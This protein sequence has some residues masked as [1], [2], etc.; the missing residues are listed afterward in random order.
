MATY[1]ELA[2]TYATNAKNEYLNSLSYLTDDLAAQ[3]KLDQ[4]ALTQKYNNLFDQINRQQD[5]VN[6]QYTQDA[7]SAY[8]NKLLAG[9]ALDESLSQ[10]GLSTGGF[11]VNQR[12][13]N[14]T[15]YGQNLAALQQTRSE[16]LRDIANQLTDAM[17]EYN[18][19]NTQLGSDYLARV[20]A[21]K[22][23]Q[24]AMADEQ[25]QLAYNQFL[26]DLKY[27]DQLKQYQE[28]F[29]YQ[30][31]QDEIANAQK[32]AQI[33]ASKSS[34]SGSNKLG[35]YATT[36][37]NQ[38]ANMYKDY[39][40]DGTQLQA[41]EKTLNDDLAAGMIS[42]EEYNYMT[43]LFGIRTAQNN[44]TTSKPISAEEHTERRYAHLQSVINNNSADESTIIQGITNSL[45]AGTLSEKQAEEL[46]DLLERKRKKQTLST[47]VGNY[48][49]NT[50]PMSTPLNL[51]ST[52]L[53]MNYSTK[54]Q[55]WGTFPR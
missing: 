2:N 49:N 25:Y 50:S 27:Q 1:N 11:G 9:R 21:A 54:L 10:L 22:T 18:V 46:F 6:Q 3:N 33:N 48:T 8:L 13:A 52:N 55:N 28:Q 36:R 26:N 7:Q 34:G 4:E 16:G 53:P 31:A 29:E 30:K 32:W 37:F 44:T 40:T 42:S 20:L 24:Q 45:D 12:L 15:A 38:L 51:G 19:A 17:G 41:I 43:N 14:E 35:S 47:P 5:V 23:Q 39:A